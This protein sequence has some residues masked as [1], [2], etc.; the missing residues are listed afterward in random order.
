M[1]PDEIKKLVGIK[2]AEYVQDGMIVGMGTGSTANH[3]IRAL[4][5]RVRQG[6]KI[7]AVPTS[8]QTQRLAL[9]QG[10]P[11]VD[12]ND[13]ATID[14]AMDGADEVSVDRNL[15]KGGGGALLQEKMIAYAAAR[16]IV[17]ADES[18]LVPRL[19]KFPL[20]VEVVPYAWKKVKAYIETLGCRDVVLRNRN[21]D[22]VV[23]DHG[24]NILDCHFELIDDPL[25][26]EQQLHSIPGVVETGLFVGFA[27]AAL[28]GYSDGSVREI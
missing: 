14:I 26:L 5:G 1:A 13:A 17:I 16:F 6:L 9:E 25:K 8:L 15:I 11:V 27:D 3:F 24:H 28:I 22:I 10:I 20:A 4:A 2:A 19:G 23:T 18:K 12:F 21:E 7:T